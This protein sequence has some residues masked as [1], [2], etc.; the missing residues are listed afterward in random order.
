MGGS[1]KRA[2]RS[3]S[4]TSPFAE[5]GGDPC[6]AGRLESASPRR[7]GGRGVSPEGRPARPGYG[8]GRV[9]IDSRR[10]SAHGGLVV[11]PVGEHVDP[12]WFA[13]AGSR[14]SFAGQGG[15]PSSRPGSTVQLQRSPRSCTRDSPPMNP[16]VALRSARSSLAGAE[17]SGRRSVGIHRIGTGKTANDGPAHG[18]DAG[19]PVPRR[20]SRNGTRNLKN[21]EI[22]ASCPDDPSAR[23]RARGARA[24]EDGDG[25]CAGPARAKRFAEGLS[26]FAE[27]ESGGVIHEHRQ[28]PPRKNARLRRGRSGVRRRS[29]DSRH[30]RPGAKRR[31]CPGR[32]SR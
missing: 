18:R 9:V 15:V 7:A 26:R 1:R 16:I 12:R 27:P 17:A 32:G 2:A 14:R 29:D 20:F 11:G 22:R 28:R 10:R 6:A 13:F 25:G 31:S 30:G 21:G 4:T 23:R 8:R 19:A 24:R 3:V 5:G